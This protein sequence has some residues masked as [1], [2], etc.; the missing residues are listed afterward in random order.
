MN[1]DAQQIWLV[2][3]KHTIEPSTKLL[4]P[5]G[6]IE[7]HHA[8]NRE[9]THL[10]V[11]SKTNFAYLTYGPAIYLAEMGTDNK[12]WGKL[13]YAVKVK[14]EARVLNGQFLIRDSEQAKRVFQKA[15]P[16]F[17]LWMHR[18]FKKFDYP[19][20]VRVKYLLSAASDNH[21]GLWLCGYDGVI[22]HGLET[23]IFNSDAIETVHPL[24]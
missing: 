23:A 6:D 18:H 2:Y 11:S 17:T 13:K 9:L 14:D 8:T 5:V 3:E 19:Q 16:E 21:I 15:D 10:D 22:D 1:N 7:F 4:I 12:G 20:G 24:D